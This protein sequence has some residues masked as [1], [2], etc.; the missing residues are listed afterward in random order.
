M[1]TAELYQANSLL[2]DEI[3]K[4]E[5]SKDYALAKLLFQRR[6]VTARGITDA[7]ALHPLDKRWGRQHPHNS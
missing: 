2:R 3:A 7:C 5:K 4:A 1:T 6:L